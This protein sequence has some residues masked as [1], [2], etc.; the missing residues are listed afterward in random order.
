MK[1]VRERWIVRKLHIQPLISCEVKPL[2]DTITKVPVVFFGFFF[3]LLLAITVFFSSVIIFF[4][5]FRIIGVFIKIAILS[6]NNFIDSSFINKYNIGRH[7]CLSVLLLNTTYFMRINSFILLGS[8]ELCRML[9]LCPLGR[10][11]TI[12]LY[13]PEIFRTS[14]PIKQ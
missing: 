6:T 3:A 7:L 9:N 13:K 1:V 8:S 12:K 10:P 5:A 2:W 14:L 11:M 4:A